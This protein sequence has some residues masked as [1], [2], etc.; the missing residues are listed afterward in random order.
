[1]KPYSHHFTTEL[2]EHIWP[3]SNA[4]FG[5]VLQQTGGRVACEIFA[6]EGTFVF[7][8]ANPEAAE[9]DIIRD[10]FAFHFL[11]DKNFRHIPTLLKTRA[12]E[13][14]RNVDGR[15]VYVMEHIEGSKE[16]RSP[17]KW[18]CLAEIAAELHDITDYP[19]ES[20]F[21]IQSELAQLEERAAELPFRKEFMEVVKELP[22]FEGLSQSV[23][24]TDLGL[25]NAIVQP[26]KT[27]ILVD[28]D[29]V[30]VGTTIL[31]LGFPLLFYFV[32]LEDFVTE[33]A[34]LV[35]PTKLRS[36]A[37]AFYNAYFSKRTLPDR[38]KDLIFDAGL[39][40]ALIYTPLGDVDRNWQR[41]KFAMKNRDLIASV[42]SG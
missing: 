37:T 21:T 27:M 35:W 7:K 31:D 10:T 11:K 40:L 25:D 15:F 4:K 13:N 9:E 33:K 14:Y 2:F 39:F 22:S 41:I 23:I 36:R 8:G 28:W 32:D 18:A 16:G 6:N 3:F 29:D 24:H 26:D 42:L 20:L 1:M 5:K 17:E 34:G 12:G 38:E 19:Y 30:G